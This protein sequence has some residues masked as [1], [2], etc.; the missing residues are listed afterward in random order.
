MPNEKN[1]ITLSE[2]GEKSHSNLQ[3]FNAVIGKNLGSATIK[4]SMPLR[5]FCRRSHVSNKYNNEKKL[6]HSTLYFL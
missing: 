3:W 5:D 6:N 4:M 1:V 2:L